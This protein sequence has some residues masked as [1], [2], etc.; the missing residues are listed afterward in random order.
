MN[1]TI[2]PNI[3]LQTAE[4]FL[5]ASSMILVV[6]S[7]RSG[8]GISWDSTDYMAVGRNM[9][10]GIGTLDVVGLPMTVRPPGI[11]SLICVGDWLGLMP[12]ASFVLINTVSAGVSTYFAMLILKKANIRTPIAFFTLAIIAF[13]PS[14][15]NMYSMAWSEP[16]F[17]ALVMVAL[18]ISLSPR[19]ITVHAILGILFT[20]MF[21]IRYVGP[22]YSFPIALVAILIQSKRSGLI[23]STFRIGAIY[24]VSLVPQ[25]LW[26]QRNESIDGTLTGARQGAGGSYLEPIKTMLG[27]FGSWI[28]GRDPLNGNGGIYLNWNDYSTIMK[29]AGYFFGSIL[30]LLVFFLI[31]SRKK[32]IKSSTVGLGL[33][34]VSLFYISFSVI[35]FVHL[36]IGPLDNRMMSGIYIPLVLVFGTGLDAALKNISSKKIVSV[37]FAVLLFAIGSQSVLS[38]FEYGSNGRYWGSDAHQKQPLHRFVKTLDAKSQFMSNEPQMLFSIIEQSPIFNQYMNARVFPKS[39]TDRYFVWYT[40]SFLPDAKPIGGEIIYSDSVGEVIQLADCTVPTPIF[41]P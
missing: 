25:Y 34:F 27:T 10:S 12:S 7:T 8:M 19:S 26:L 4:Y 1:L 35:R 18:W 6:I 5:I 17:I 21:F 41:W 3:K 40:V 23:K 36:E 2:R 37:L 33:F 31:R 14:L 38:S 16:V 28:V 24:F 29:I 11:S 22:F 20:S 13:S 30:I 39:C 15:L 9:A 32:N